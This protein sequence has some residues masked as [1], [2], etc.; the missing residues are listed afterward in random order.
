MAAEVTTATWC[1]FVEFQRVLRPNCSGLTR[2]SLQA[3][4]NC[5][6][7]AISLRIVRALSPAFV[8]CL[9]Q[10]PHD[11]QIQRSLGPKLVGLLHSERMAIKSAFN[12]SDR[13]GF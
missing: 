6:N 8:N 13:N 2:R 10:Q 7:I 1:R 4:V 5:R 9:R 3:K 12:S 11:R